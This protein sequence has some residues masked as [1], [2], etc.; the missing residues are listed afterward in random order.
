MEQCTT[1]TV[2]HKKAAVLWQFKYDLNGNLIAFLVQ[3]KPLSKNQISFLFAEQKLPYHEKIMK[4]VWM[5]AKKSEFEITVGEPDLSFES[6]YNAY[7]RKIKKTKAETAWKRLS[8]KDKI[9]AFRG[10]SK[11]N[12]YLHRTKV[13]KQNPEAYINQ[14]RWEDDFNSI[15]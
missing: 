14:R 6:F 13:A 4:E 12:G 7:D 5:T 10:I 11:Y 9:E 15:H 1:Y 8:K 3:D 2:S